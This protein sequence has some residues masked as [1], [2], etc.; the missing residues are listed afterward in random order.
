MPSSPRAQGVAVYLGPLPLKVLAEVQRLSWA[1]ESLPQRLPGA[2]RAGSAAERVAHR[3]FA[4]GYSKWGMR[5]SLAMLSVVVRFC[6]RKENMMPARYFA[7][8]DPEHW[9]AVRLSWQC[10]HIPFGT[11]LWGALLTGCVLS[12]CFSI[13]AV[14]PST[15]L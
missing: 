12:A 1:S 5:L 13:A 8:R 9:E 11:L 15:P 6:M 10:C 7:H 3:K 14:G 4:P 2:R